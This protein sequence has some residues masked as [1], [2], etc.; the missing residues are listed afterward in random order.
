[1]TTDVGSLFV[2]FICH[3]FIFLVKYLLNFAHLKNW[4]RDTWMAQ[5]EEHATLDLTVMTLSPTLGVEIK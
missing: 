2:C 3:P 1:M 5:L 4:V